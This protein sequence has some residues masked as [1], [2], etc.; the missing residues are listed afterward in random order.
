MRSFR[1]GEI[2]VVFRNLI[3]SS[4]K[5]MNYLFKTDFQ[6]DYMFI[7][8]SFFKEIKIDDTDLSFFSELTKKISGVIFVNSIEQYTLKVN[9]A[10][11]NNSFQEEDEKETTI[12]RVTALDNNKKGFTITFILEKNSDYYSIVKTNLI[13]LSTF[14][15]LKELPFSLLGKPFIE[16]IDITLGNEG[17]IESYRV[18]FRW[19]DNNDEIYLFHYYT[20]TKEGIKLDIDLYD[21]MSIVMGTE[22]GEKVSIEYISADVIEK[23]LLAFNIIAR[24]QTS[25]YLQEYFKYFRNIGKSSIKIEEVAKCFARVEQCEALEL[26]KVLQLEEMLKS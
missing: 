24:I 12:I 16:N 26:Y 8:S 13:F 21:M 3:K 20:L 4:E 18:K 10:R 1:H 22:R 23:K 9:V 15:E 19:Q 7:N 6:S 2:I 5:S 17:E 11:I 25:Q 14:L